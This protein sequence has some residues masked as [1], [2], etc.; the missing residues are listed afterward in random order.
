VTTLAFCSGK[1]FYD[2]AKSRQERADL[3]VVLTRIEELYPLPEKEIRE[4]L[5]AYPGVSDVVWVQEEARNMG[6]WWFMQER[7]RPLLEPH[8]SLRYAGR[9][10]AASPATGSYRL[11]AKEQA[12]LLAAVFDGAPAAPALAA[13]AAGS[14]ANGALPSESAGDAR[15]SAASATPGAAAAAAET[16]PRRRLASAARANQKARN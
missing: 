1:V 16:A 3:R 15:T 9:D 8:Q 2:L 4:V 5:A 11:H 6:A 12:A 13:K 14:G 10:E 7:L